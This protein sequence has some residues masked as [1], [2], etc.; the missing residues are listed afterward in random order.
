[1]ISMTGYGEWEDR[2]D[3]LAV[4]VEIRTTNGRF[5]KLSLK[6]P[7]GYGSL[8]NDI[9]SLV[10]S[11]IKRGSVQVALRIQRRRRP[12]DYRINE[13]ALL[14]YRRQ[15]EALCDQW[16]LP[17]QVRP[18]A[19][20]ALPGVVDEETP[21]VDAHADWPAVQRAVQA[22][23]GQLE[24]MRRREGEAMAAELAALCDQIQTHLEAVHQR[25]PLVVAAY[26][27]RLL[28]RVREILDEHHLT[29]QPADLI[30]EV[31]VFADRSDVSEEIVRLR[32]HT[33]QFRRETQGDDESSGRKLEFL[34]QEMLRE[35][36]T[37]GSKA[38]DVEIARHV[39]EIKTTIEKIR[40]L[41][42]NVE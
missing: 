34:S 42:Q 25:A 1:M 27:Q 19:L 28:D 37:I 13:V 38:N 21:T 40:E 15:L 24:A 35:A 14:A 12:E 29:V 5:F 16:K 20:L 30:R 11:R 3:D 17:G 9:E 26:G 31:S 39:I 8:E 41:I 6:A 10:R 32:S 18:E 4:A 7:E 22:A 23:L 2:Q 33:E 36:N